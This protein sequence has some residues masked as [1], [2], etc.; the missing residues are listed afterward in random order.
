MLTNDLKDNTYQTGSTNMR[1]NPNYDSELRRDDH[2]IF[3]VAHRIEKDSLN[4]HP[5]HSFKLATDRRRH[6][7]SL[8]GR[9]TYGSRNAQ[10]L[11]T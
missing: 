10:E 5:R 3:D 11:F 2:Q 9:R 7:P 6:L 8:A 1:S 4:Y